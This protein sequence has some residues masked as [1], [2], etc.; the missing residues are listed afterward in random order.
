MKSIKIALIYGFI[1]WVVP[2]LVALFIFTLRASNRALFESIMAV[3]LTASVVFFT[4]KYFKIV[5]KDFLHEGILV[6]LLWFVISLALDFPMFFAGPMKMGAY[7]Y[8][9]DIGFTYLVIPIIV[10]GFGYV[11]ENRNIE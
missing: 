6:G 11:L 5:A 4:V 8:V 7:E 2:F 10:A 3:V 1:I 9:S